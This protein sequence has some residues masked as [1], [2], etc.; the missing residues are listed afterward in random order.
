MMTETEVAF[1]A[2]LHEEKFSTAA[3]LLSQLVE[4]HYEQNSHLTPVQILRLQIGC[5]QL[6]VQRP[7]VGAAALIQAAYS[8]LPSNSAGNF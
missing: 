3:V 5:Q 4:A 1:R 7:E 8:Y 2:A 6:L